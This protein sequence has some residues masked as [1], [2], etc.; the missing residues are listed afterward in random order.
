MLK[1]WKYTV[2][3]RQR[4]D[5]FLPAQLGTW[6]HPQSSNSSGSLEATEEPQT[7]WPDFSELQTWE[8]VINLI[9]IS[10]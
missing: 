1:K 4:N 7:G 5:I 6:F 10:M 9:S 8:T 2:S 3:Q